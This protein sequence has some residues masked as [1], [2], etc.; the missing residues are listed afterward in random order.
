MTTPSSAPTTPSSAP[1][2]SPVT[3]PFTAAA[4][5]PLVDAF[6]DLFSRRKD[7]GGALAVYRHGEPVVDV[8]AGYQDVEARTP[9]RADTMA[10]SYSTSKGVTATLV[11]RLIQRGVLDVEQPIAHYW[12]AFGQ[13]G[14]DD[15]TL[16]EL[17]SHQAG[18]H[19]I[20]GVA[21]TPG[22]LLDHRVMAKQLAARRPSSLR[23]RPAYHAMTFGYLLA[24]VIEAATGRD[25]PAVLAEE[26]TTPLGLD[27]C[28]ISTPA[29]QQHRIA[30]FYQR[31]APLGISM[32][33]IGHYA[34]TLR[35]FRPAVNALLPHGLDQFANTPAMWEAVIPAAN[36]VF[37]ARS[38][39]RMYAPLA[40]GGWIEGQQFLQPEVLGEAGRVQTRSR[41]VVLG[42]RMRWRLGYHQGFVAG[43]DQPRRAFG[44]YGLG[45]SGGWADPDTGLSL[46]FVTNRLSAATTPVADARLAKLGAVAHSCVHY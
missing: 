45:G 6:R 2:T 11:H 1:T 5:R 16:R 32:D 15:I 33:T 29:D 9:W 3:E 38:L 46:G 19:R 21:D 40:A 41:D 28:F 34:K 25:F 44:H 17:L 26:V 23:G 8:W 27:G 35:R 24:A 12:P 13:R 7:G 39:A 37:T 10:M 18:M 36:G 20:R 42:L 43:S 4:F 30:P 22:D 31:L 14:K